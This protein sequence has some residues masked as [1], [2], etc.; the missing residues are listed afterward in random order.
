[1]KHSAVKAQYNPI[2]LRILRLTT[3]LLIIMLAGFYAGRRVWTGPDNL[4]EPG[5]SLNQHTLR[6]DLPEFVLTDLSGQARSIQDWSQ[7]TL[8]INFW[9]TWCAPCRREMPLLQTVHQERQD[10]GLRVIGIA[11]DRR[12]DV[13]AFIAE[14]G[15]TYPILIGQQD[16]MEAAETFG[17]DFVGLPFSIFVAPGGHVLSIH[18]GELHPAEL[19]AILTIGDRVASGQLDLATAR[20]TLRGM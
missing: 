13:E 9:A 20:E 18:S 17:P 2:V 19:K 3:L 4:P 7:H 15:V 1:M 14:S 12:S 11:V 16:A 5:V 8:L 6:P 10:H